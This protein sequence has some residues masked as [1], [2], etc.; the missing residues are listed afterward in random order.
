MGSPKVI[1]VRQNWLKE[2]F[3]SSFLFFLTAAGAPLQQTEKRKEKVVNLVNTTDPPCCL[4]MHYT[5][6]HVTTHTKSYS[7]LFLDACKSGRWAPLSC[8]PVSVESVL[9]MRRFPNFAEKAN[10]HATY[11]SAPTRRRGKTA[12]L[13]S[14]IHRLVP[15]HAVSMHREQKNAV[16]DSTDAAECRAYFFRFVYNLITPFEM[17]LEGRALAAG[18]LY[19]PQI[20]NVYFLQRRSMLKVTIE[21]PAAL[22]TAATAVNAA[23]TRIASSRSLGESQHFNASDTHWRDLR[24]TYSHFIPRKLRSNGIL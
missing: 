17:R 6:Q 8:P 16:A 11:A 13:Q 24:R 3:F 22:A 1:A 4:R 2:C 10:T 23:G 19:T 12:F 9:R 18:D 7:L 14:Y 15:D 5:L 20:Q 21:R